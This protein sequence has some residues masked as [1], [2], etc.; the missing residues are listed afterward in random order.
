MPINPVLYAIQNLQQGKSTGAFR[1]VRSSP[2]LADSA[3]SRIDLNS[4]YSEKFGDVLRGSGE[5]RKVYETEL[6]KLIASSNTLKTNYGNE[7]AYSRDT[8]LPGLYRELWKNEGWGISY[9]N[10]PGWFKYKDRIRT[11]ERNQ[12]NR[13]LSYNTS[14]TNNKSAADAQY[15]IY[16]GAAD[17]LNAEY[18]TKETAMDKSGYLAFAAPDEEA[19]SPSTTG[20]TLASTDLYSDSLEAQMIDRKQQIQ[21]SGT[22]PDEDILTGMMQSSLYQR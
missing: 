3:V 4:E 14:I 10:N 16:T 12:R 2:E 8:A 11:E 22:T 6:E 17:R 18:K 19:V 7:S 21:K 1:G 9:R 13:T 20:E 5:R 15:E